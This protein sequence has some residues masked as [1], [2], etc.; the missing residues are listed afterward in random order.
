VQFL[1]FEEFDET[2]QGL[3]VFWLDKGP[4]TDEKL[5]DNE[6]IIELGVKEN[7]RDVVE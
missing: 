7:A 5:E 1:I 3:F 4:C 6:K 2:L